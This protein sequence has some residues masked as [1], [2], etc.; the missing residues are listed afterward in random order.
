MCNID[1]LHHLL[2]LAIISHSAHD[3]AA[4]LREQLAESVAEKEQLRMMNDNLQQAQSSLQHE[5]EQLKQEKWQLMEEKKT[6]VSHV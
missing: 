1:I 5:N 6:Q 2:L 4:L 3:G